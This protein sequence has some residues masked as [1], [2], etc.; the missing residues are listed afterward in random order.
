MTRLDEILNM[1]AVAGEAHMI[2]VEPISKKIIDAYDN[3]ADMYCTTGNNHFE[4]ITARDNTTR[5][6]LGRIIGERPTTSTGV[7]MAIKLGI[8]FGDKDLW[9]YAS[10]EFNEEELAKFYNTSND[11]VKLMKMFDE[12]RKEYEI[13]NKQLSK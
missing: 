3:A 10:N 5:N 12:K 4:S 8:I 11:N 6:V 7:L 1:P 13:F 2:C 9:E